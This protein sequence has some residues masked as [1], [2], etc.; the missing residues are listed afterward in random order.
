MRRTC[1]CAL[2]GMSWSCDNVAR[3]HR[4]DIRSCMWPAVLRKWQTYRTDRGLAPVRAIRFAFFDIDDS[5]FGCEFL[6]R[7]RVRLRVFC[8][9]IA[10]LYAVRAVGRAAF[11]GMRCL[12]DCPTMA[13]F[14]R[15]FPE[16]FIAL[17]GIS[18]PALSPDASREGVC[19]CAQAIPSGRSS[20]NLP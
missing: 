13:R 2:P 15:A 4:C 5:L 11:G 16:W 9:M 14:A 19:C 6:V 20:V 3:C 10:H 8:W 17:P 18:F 1:L 7:G 12:H